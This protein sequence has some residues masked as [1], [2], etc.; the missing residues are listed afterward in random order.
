MGDTHEYV[1]LLGLH[2]ALWLCLLQYGS[3]FQHTYHTRHC[4]DVAGRDG[5]FAVAIT[6]QAAN[7][8]QWRARG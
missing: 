8:L 5:A 3:R 4:E 2:Y 6:Y 1:G 7:T